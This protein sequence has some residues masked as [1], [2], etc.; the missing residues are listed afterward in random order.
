[1]GKLHRAAR[2]PSCSPATRL[3][4]SP[5]TS[6][7]CRSC[8]RPNRALPYSITLSARATNVA[9][10]VT[11]IALAVLRLDHQFELGGLFDRQVFRLSAAQDFCNKTCCLPLDQR[12]TGAVSDETTLFR[13]FRVL[14]DRWQS[15]G[16]SPVGR[17]DVSGGAAARWRSLASGNRRAQ[18]SAARGE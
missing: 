5:P 16:G 14:V 15:S 9:G 4:A 2:R 10:T 18:S 13:H 1:M 3:G 7:S 6:P 12:K 8:Y 11:P 17:G